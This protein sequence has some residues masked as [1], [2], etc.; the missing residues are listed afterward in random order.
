MLAR[1]VYSCGVSGSDFSHRFISTKTFPCSVN[2]QLYEQLVAMG[3]SKGASAA[4]LKQ[5]DNDLDMSLKVTT[6]PECVFVVFCF[7]AS[8]RVSDFYCMI[9]RRWRRILSC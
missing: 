2:I 3:F 9:D 8:D 4:A 1:R 5:T 7:F 6:H